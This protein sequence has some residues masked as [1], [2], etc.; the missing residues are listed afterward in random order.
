MSY[1]LEINMARTFRI[2]KKIL[3]DEAYLKEINRYPSV[4]D[5]ADS[6]DIAEEIAYKI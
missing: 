6:E 1:I 5:D 4:K 2:D 3:N